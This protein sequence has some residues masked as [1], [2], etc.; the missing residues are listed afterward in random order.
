MIT[1]LT[2]PAGLF[3]SRALLSISMILFIA[4]ACFH[5]NILQQVQSCFRQKFFIGLILLF[6]IPLLSGLWSA[7][8]E[9]WLDVVRIKLPLFL[10]PLAFAGDWQLSGRQW[11]TI[12]FL[13]VLLL[14]G[15]CSWSLWQYA[16]DVGAINES[17]LKAKSIP[18][19]F[20][21][22]HVRYSWIV[23][24]AAAGI[25]LILPE[26]STR[27]HQALSI[28][29]VIFFVIYLHILSARTGLFCFYFFILIYFVRSMFQSANKKVLYS[30][31]IVLFLMPV[32]AWLAMPTFQNR[33]R[34][35]VY[36][37]SFIEKGAYFPGGNDGNRALSFKA[38]WHIL[39]NNFFG[40]GAGDIRTAANGW[41]TANVP[42]MQETDKLLPSSEW[43]VYGATA[44]WI[45]VVIFTAIMFIPLA[46]EI[47][48][49]RFAWIA[50]NSMAALSFLFDIG[51]EVQFGVFLYTFSI[52]CFYK[53]IN[54]ENNLPAAI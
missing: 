35:I 39:T 26:F 13:F 44:G 4:F 8:S 43:L 40:V 34:Y 29:V 38:G 22:D 50:I 11:R 41:Y 48:R 23:A 49:H 46:L 5:K 32:V 42:A 2:M 30:L 51:L 20:E 24:I 54:A 3:F 53:W 10:F 33:V 15:G 16:A 1:L 28:S 14:V 18:T 37:F 12:F 17:Y 21:N 52:L 6:S 25:I 27:G 31:M 7:D 9:T 45:G 36:D 19:P 47:R